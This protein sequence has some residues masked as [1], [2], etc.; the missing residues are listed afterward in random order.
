MVVTEDREIL[1]RIALF[2]CL[3]DEDFDWVVR[4]AQPVEV[5]KGTTLT[6][7]GDPGDSMFVITDGELEIVKRSGNSDVP[8]ARL[9]PGEIV[10]EM[11]VLE[12]T[13]RNAS[14]RAVTDSRVVRIGRD[15][16]LELV[17]TRPSAAMSVI[18]TVT[19]RLRSSEAMLREREKLASLGTL[20]AG[21][22]HE[23][24]NPAAAVSRST[25]LLREALDRWSAT[26][27]GLGSV[28]A[29]ATAARMVGDLGG[30][31]AARAAIGG[32]SDPL[33]A[34][35]LRDAI[36]RLLDEHGVEDAFDLAAALADGGWDIEALEAVAAELDGPAFGA[37]A[38]WL[39]AGATVHALVG[40]VAMG[41]RRISEIVRAVKEYTFMDQAPMQ[42]VDV[43]TGL[44]NTLVIL[45]PKLRHG[46]EVIRD[47]ADELPDIEA[48]GS[49]LNQVWT[50]LIDNAV[51]AMG[52]QGRLTIG[53]HVRDGDVV[54]SICD[55]GPGIPPDVRE[56]IF[57]PFYTTKELG[58]GTG[59]GLH[60]SYN[61]VARHGGRID[62]RSRPGETCFEVILPV[63]GAAG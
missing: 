52:G 32:P 6:A 50:N 30:D 34:G 56:R 42:A 59:L 1:R 58:K 36:E 18:R 27:R 41:A 25:S 20:S 24:N 60:I 29:E 11:A 57:E 23:L 9:G 35:D 7:E 26:T 39:A 3:S 21:L 54:V 51:D 43:R 4:V 38:A 53:A 55:D 5:T 63:G 40:E 22:A 13:T 46:V 47:Y 12:D 19:G 62:V 17:Q 16:V 37:V 15:V 45:R 28:I 14:V 8:I 44:D 33:D 2:A 49:E 31:I 61:V 10:G 48:Y